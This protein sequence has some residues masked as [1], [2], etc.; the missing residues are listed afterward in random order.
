MSRPFGSAAELE[1][2]RR[3][4]VERVNQGEPPSL[5]ARVL[6]IPRSTLYRWRQA[7][8]VGPEGLTAKPHAGRPPRLSDRQLRQLETWLRQ[9]ADVH[10]W[11]NRLWT[12]ARIAQL[13]RRHFGVSYHPDHLGRLLHTRLGWTPQKPRRQARER[14][15]EAVAHWQRYVFPRLAHESFRRGAHLV[16]L[17]ESGFQLTP[18][19]RR[20][21]APRGHTPRL[22][23][24]DRRDRI[25]A[26]S[27]LTVSPRRRRQNLVF[28][29]LPDNVNVHAE[30][31]VAFLRQVKAQLGGGPLTVFWDGSNVHDKARAVRAYLARHADVRTHRLPPYAPD[32]NPDEGVWGWTKYGRLANLAAADVDWLREYVINDLVH[33]R[34]HPELL[35]SFIAQTGLVIPDAA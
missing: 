30:D 4:A 9:G 13:V 31:V 22:R 18:C 24:W 12:T 21:W 32:L 1:R 33:L 10:G 35:H 19:L 16:F 2:R 7:A 34:E 20:T 25:S 3:R 29:L 26:L 15:D 6:G 28:D 14:D 11:P 8:R 27:A 17:D 5:V 23:T